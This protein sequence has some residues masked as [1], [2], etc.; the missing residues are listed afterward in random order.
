MSEFIVPDFFKFNTAT[1][2]STP[3]DIDRVLYTTAVV[4]VHWSL[5]RCRRLRS[6]GDGQTSRQAAILT[7]PRVNKTKKKKKN[8]KRTFCGVLDMGPPPLIIDARRR[9]HTTM[10]FVPSTGGDTNRFITY[11]YVY[12]YIYVCWREYS[13]P[14]QNPFHRTRGINGVNTVTRCYRRRTG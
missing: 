13:T 11:V 14:P 5:Y 4:V 2:P 10:V 3:D 8:V 6:A 1:V 7:P 9:P 12:I